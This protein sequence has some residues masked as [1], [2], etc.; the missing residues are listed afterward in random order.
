MINPD[1]VY[2]GHYRSDTRGV[3]LNRVYCAPQPATHPSVLAICALVRSM[4]AAGQLRFY[5]DCHAHSNKRGCFLF[6]NALDD[7]NEMTLNVMYAKLVQQNCRWF[8]FDGCEFKFSERLA[9]QYASPSW[10]LDGSL[11]AP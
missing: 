9:N 1:G 10:L 7:E 3:N 6:G 11:M 2:H 5:V 4:H 8:D